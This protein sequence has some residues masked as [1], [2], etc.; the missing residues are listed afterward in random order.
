MKYLAF[1]EIVRNLLVYLKGQ[2]PSL[3]IKRTKEE[4]IKQ[5]QAITFTLRSSI[6][7]LEGSA[8]QDPRNSSEYHEIENELKALRQTNTR[9]E[10]SLFL[11]MNKTQDFTSKLNQ[12]NQDYEKK[13]KE[14]QTRL[15]NSRGSTEPSE[16]SKNQHELD[17]YLNELNQKTDYIS[18][19]EEQ[20][21]QLHQT[22]EQLESQ[23]RAIESAT[24]TDHKVFDELKSE[25]SH[26]ESD[27]STSHETISQLKQAL[28]NKEIEVKKVQEALVEAMRMDKSEINAL[29]EQLAE[30]STT[31][32]ANQ[33]LK[34]RLSMLESEL[35]SL[36]S[37]EVIKNNQAA[38]EAKIK[39]LE[40]SLEETSEKLQHAIEREQNSNPEILMREKEE[41]QLRV[42]D[43]ESTLKSIVKT[44]EGGASSDKFAFTPEECV[45]MFETLS[46]SIL[47][48]EHSAENRDLYQRSKEA[49][50]ILQKANAIQKILTVGQIY[51]KRVH[52]AVKSF[53]SDFIPDDTI[54]YEESAGF[55][56]SSKVIQRAIVWV[57]KSSFT[58]GECNNP[59]RDH[60]FFC[61]KCGLELTAP[62]GTSKRD[63]PLHPTA[64]ETNLALLDELIKQNN[65]RSAN[66]L[67]KYL[68]KEHPDNSE[69][70]KRQS[71][72]SRAD[73]KGSEQ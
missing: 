3:Q 70:I 21:K 48:L 9:L 66:G 44:R 35:R 61:P 42:L 25:I 23:P 30:I 40:T 36:P 37:P 38:A 69:L 27:L 47:R 18:Q 16:G 64:V 68:S 33:D 59:C 71:F 8:Q 26:L 28:Q 31:K 17:K 7:Q 72:L 1:D 57:G 63:L 39:F 5:I 53:R 43:L 6:V 65:Y 11:E 4:V 73:S 14:L 15:E 60:D 19:L 45:F 49:I 10:E 55:V 13:I 22:I 20:I 41:L 58:C 67:I 12:L 62:D 32:Q 56:S 2:I 24:P 51:E 29:K 50:N 46:T 34:A 54:I 52:K